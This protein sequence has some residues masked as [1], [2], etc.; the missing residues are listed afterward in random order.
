MSTPLDPIVPSYKPLHSMCLLFLEFVHK[1][2]KS[3]WSN[4]AAETNS[5]FTNHWANSK[6]KTPNADVVMRALNAQTTTNASPSIFRVFFITPTCLSLFE[7][8]FGR[9]PCY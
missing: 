2:S 4:N 5:P 9:S 8:D 7:F 3:Q 6:V 1:Y